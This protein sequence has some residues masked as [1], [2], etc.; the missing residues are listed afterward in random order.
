MSLEHG[1]MVERAD[2]GAAL[3]SPVAGNDLRV[4]GHVLIQEKPCK[5]ISLVRSA[6]G[7][8][9]HAK[10]SVTGVDIFSGK[11]Y[12]GGGPASHVMYVPVIKRTSFQVLDIADDGFLSL[13][14]PLDTERGI[15]DDLKLAENAVGAKVRAM[16]ED[17]KEVTVVVLASMGMETVTECTGK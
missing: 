4:N 5:L 14:N 10:I 1:D 6:P 12:E 15:K 3:S 9:G 11:K 16:L 7:K 8:H 2:A 13:W 17:G